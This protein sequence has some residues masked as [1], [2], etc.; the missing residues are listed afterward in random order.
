MPRR[1]P[2]APEIDAILAFLPKLEE[3]RQEF[4]RSEMGD[5]PYTVRN[6]ARVGRSREGPG[7]APSSALDRPDTSDPAA[8]ATMSAR[9]G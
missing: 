3:P 1:L 4:A 5:P 9:M 7:L 6:A 8:R 2:K